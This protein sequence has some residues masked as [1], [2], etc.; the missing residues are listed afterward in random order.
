MQTLIRILYRPLKAPLAVGR[1][2]SAVLTLLLPQA[3]A[4]MCLKKASMATVMQGMIDQLQ[5]V[6]EKDKQTLENITENL[7]TKIE[8]LNVEAQKKKQQKF[9]QLND[10]LM[11]LKTMGLSQNSP[12][13]IVA[14]KLYKSSYN[15]F[16]FSH[17]D[18]DQQRLEYL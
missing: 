8:Q 15:R 1:D 11:E 10:C 16:I 2:L 3:R 12:E 7:Y 17:Y 6:S 4:C 13:Y 18:T 14:T 9:D 5:I